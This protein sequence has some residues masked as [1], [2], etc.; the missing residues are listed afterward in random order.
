[1]KKFTHDSWPARVHRR[2][3]LRGVAASAM[4]AILAA[5]GSGSTPTATNAPTSAPTTAPTVAPPS[6]TA[7]TAPTVASA[8]ST[9][10]APTVAT[11]A[12]TATTAA[13]SSV[14]SVAT[15]ST[16]Q[17]KG[18][19]RMA[20][21]LDFPPSVDATKGGPGLVRFG[22]AETLTRV[23]IKSAIEPWLAESVTN[24]D[25]TTW[26]VTLRAN[27]TF[28]DGAPVTA[29]AVVAAFKTNWETQPSAVLALDK[30]T[31]IT[32]VNPTTLE[33]K[34]T[35]PLGNFPNALSSQYLTIHK[36]NGMVMTGPYKVA[37]FEVDRE[38]ALEAFP[39]HWDGPPPI[40]RISVKLVP[41]ANTR[42]LALQAGDLDFLYGLP[43][44]LLKNFGND[45]ETI[46]IP[47][48]RVHSLGFNPNRL[49]FSDHAVREATALAL[50]RTAMLKIGLDGQGV[51]ATGVF[52]PDMGQDVVPLQG[53]DVARAKQLLDDAG[54][55]A[56]S[57]GVRAKGGKRLAFTIYSYPGRAE[58]TPIAV[59]IQSQLKALGY[60]IQVMQVQN[61]K[62]AAKDA[63]YDALM[64][65]ANTLTT[66]DAFGLYT[67]VF[68]K[69]AV[70]N[71]SGYIMPGF[72]AL[73]EQ[74]RGE[75][76]PVKQQ[77]IS[78]QIQELI[79]SEI[80]YAFLVVPPLVVAMKKGK[81]KGYV[82]HPNDTYAITTAISVT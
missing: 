38:L 2:T 60:D 46:S 36:S 7:T 72:D 13:A 51:V 55:V 5:C 16:A 32:V 81:V 54:W 41:D 39:N 66:G 62:D 57:D 82:P 69:G 15:K 1:M 61:I 47:S 26:R 25:A 70:Q 71:Y 73:L 10:S 42:A 45:I 48:T 74:L 3:L 4:T 67:L 6:A 11:T 35:K 31:Q 14:A 52:P 18:D 65:S 63:N 8:A 58:L 22:A 17:S 68:A 80:P 9:A 19:L 34:T 77:A 37:K 12:T 49:P 79:K 40:A 30:A 29:D 28:W 24:V 20:V 21:G 44:E 23:T 50:D 75:R 64:G 27:A 53:T 56:G 43:P 76:D 78:R 59:V 33:F